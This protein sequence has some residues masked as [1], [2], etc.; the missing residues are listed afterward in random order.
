MA[1]VT[2]GLDHAKPV[3]VGRV[4]GSPETQKRHPPELVVSPEPKP[5]QERQPQR[6]G[7]HGSVENIQLTGKGARP[8]RTKKIGESEG[9]AQRAAHVR[10]GLH[11]SF[12]L[13]AKEGRRRMELEKVIP[14]TERRAVIGEGEMSRVARR[15]ESIRELQVSIPA[16]I[17]LRRPERI[18]VNL[19]QA[20]GVGSK[21]QQS[22]AGG[23]GKLLPPPRRRQ[24]ATAKPGEEVEQRAQPDPG[25][26]MARDWE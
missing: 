18:A 15:T 24:A 11:P 5:P 12:H 23:Q 1:G 20:V 14:V 7:Q 8:A 6:Y 2:E 4:P 10:E 25:R 22:Q 13:A 19:I 9:L 3:E 26:K 21:D 17:D 16:S